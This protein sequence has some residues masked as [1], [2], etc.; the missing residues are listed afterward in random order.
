MKR[1]ARLWCGEGNPPATRLACD[2]L[3]LDGTRLSVFRIHHKRVQYK[4]AIFN[5][6]SQQGS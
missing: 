3:G 4:K 1:P 6:G 2:L 5:N